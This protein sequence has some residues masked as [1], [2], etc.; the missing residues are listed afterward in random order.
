MMNFFFVPQEEEFFRSYLRE[1]TNLEQD[2]YFFK[3][4]GNSYVRLPTPLSITDF[5]YSRFKTLELISF[6]FNKAYS[7]F[8]RVNHY[9][10]KFLN[11]QKFNH[12]TKF[13]FIS[14]S[15]PT[16]IVI[17]ILIPS[18][19]LLYSLDEELHPVFTFKVAGHQ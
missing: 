3:P 19:L 15:V 2:L 14:A 17:S 6:P 13:E 4:F 11:V 1:K 18:M 5:N 9:N 7:S 8:Y 12:S 16:Y 10:T